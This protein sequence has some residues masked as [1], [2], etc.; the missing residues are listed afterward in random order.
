MTFPQLFDAFVP[1]N[2]PAFLAASNITP[3]YVPFETLRAVAIDP[4]AQAASFAYA[5]KLTPP[6]V[7]GHVIR[8]FYFALA[9]LYTGFPSGTPGVAQIGFDELALRLYH[10]TLLH[11]IGWSNATVV[12]THPAHAMTFEL[13]G[14]FM[15]YEHLHAAAPNLD[16]FQ[17][18][19]IVESIV[20]H[21]SGWS[22]G[23]SSANQ[24]LMA[25]SADFDVGGFNG[26][27]LM[28]LDF[29]QLFNPKTVAEI[30]QAYPR[31][32]FYDAGIVAFDR[33]FMEK[34]NCLL[35]HYPGGLDALS[36]DLRVGPIVPGDSRR[37]N[38]IAPKKD[39]HLHYLE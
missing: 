34:P 14:G 23:N 38:V 16:P 9:L 11:D 3:A 30:E 19:D 22:S 21:T 10:T 39:P 29:N 27:G 18:G 15:A 35:S 17:V 24:I 1:S 13:H 36:K 32:D 37:R 33:E 8:C 26:T 28:G 7:F 20:L 4:A 12:V 25:L 2:S 31:G 5:K 6:G